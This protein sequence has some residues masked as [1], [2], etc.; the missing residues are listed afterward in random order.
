MGFDYGSAHT[1]CGSSCQT[2]LRAPML[3]TQTRPCFCQNTS[4]GTF[5]TAGQG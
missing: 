5:H 2:E 4:V 1:Q 3:F